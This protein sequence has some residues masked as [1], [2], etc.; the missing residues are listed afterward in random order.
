[1]GKIQVRAGTGDA[2]YLVSRL[3]SFELQW[4]VVDAYISR[5][6]VEEA[7]RFVKQSY[8]FENIR[9]MS[10][11]RIRNMASIVL[12]SVYSATVWIGRHAKREILAEHIKWLGR[13]LN[14]VP[15]FAAYAIRH[16]GRRI[17]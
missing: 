1:M 17:K 6:R 10:Y 15:E 13:R 9:V 5:W 3:R 16:L 2:D 11:A 14:E 4:R 7:I 8:G 12:A